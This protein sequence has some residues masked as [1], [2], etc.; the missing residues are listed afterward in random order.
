[1]VGRS[2][3]ACL[4]PMD[5]AAYSASETLR[6][7]RT[8][9]IRALR[10]DDRAAMVAFAERMSDA[11][12]QLRF[13]APRHGFSEREIDY[14][15]NVDFVSHVALLAVMDEGGAPRPV[16]GGR[17]IVAT[18]GSAEIAFAVD[19]ACQGLGLASVILRHL[20]GIGRDAGLR[21]FVAEVLPENGAMLKV[22]QRSG[23]AMRTRREEGVVHVALAL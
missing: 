19:E 2:L 10:P 13:F 15:V 8:V 3:T 17:Y 14:F 6:D 9:R 11:A 7:G 16:G 12:R 18:P 21:E 4:M 5:P 23:L 20:A 1:M 22:F